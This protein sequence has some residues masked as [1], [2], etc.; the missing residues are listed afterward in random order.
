MEKFSGN[1]KTI[2]TPDCP[3]HN[4]LKFACIVDAPIFRRVG[5]AI[6]AVTHRSAMLVGYAPLARR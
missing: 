6:F 4:R 5:E 1:N 3:H 2:I